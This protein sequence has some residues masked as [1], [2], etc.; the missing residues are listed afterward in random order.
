MD[1]GALDFIKHFASHDAQKII[2]AKSWHHGVKIFSCKISTG[3][4]QKILMARRFFNKDMT[5]ERKN[6]S[7]LIKNSWIIFFS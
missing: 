6:I 5:G 1:F 3:I 7:R 4:H 2:N